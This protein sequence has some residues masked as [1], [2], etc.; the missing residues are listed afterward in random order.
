[1]KVLNRAAITIT[2]KKSFIDWHNNLF[3][4][5]KMHENMIGESKTYLV[6]ENF[7]NVDIL[8]KRH[9]KE[10]FENE[11]LENWNDENDFPKN[12]SRK[13]FDKWFDYE[14]SDFV[15]DHSSRKLDRSIFV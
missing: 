4:D 3:E 15:Y 13:L 9:Y 6:N 5:S 11:L 10:I 2:Y 12:I 1:M 8:I 14:V 7:D